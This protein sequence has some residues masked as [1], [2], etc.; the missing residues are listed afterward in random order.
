[1]APPRSFLVPVVQPIQV[2]QAPG[3]K[4]PILSAF[5]GGWETRPG[6]GHPQR[7]LACSKGA[8]SHSSRSSHLPV[9]ATRGRWRSWNRPNICSRILQT[10]AGR[11]RA[12]GDSPLRHRGRRSGVAEALRLPLKIRVASLPRAEDCTVAVCE[13]FRSSRL[14]GSVQVIRNI[15]EPSARK[16]IKRCMRF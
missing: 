12:S 6:G 3:S 8:L 2:D 11:T 10:A 9:V 13:P 1:M 14:L 5:L 7:G 15:L 16:H 4:R